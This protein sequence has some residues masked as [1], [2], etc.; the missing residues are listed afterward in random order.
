MTLLYDII[1]GRL[2][3]V[4]REIT[5][6]C[7]TLMNRA[8]PSLLRYM[9]Y[10]INSINPE[11]GPTY[12]LAKEYGQQLIENCR[13]A[14]TEDAVY[15][16]VHAPTAPHTEIDA[17]GNVAYSEVKRAG[18]RKLEAYVKE[19]AAG[20]RLLGAG[21]QV[22][23]DKAQENVAKLWTLIRNEPRLASSARPP[24]RACTAKSFDRWV[25]LAR[26]V[27]PLVRLL[28]TVA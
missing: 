19:M 26:L 11:K 10:H 12:A 21:S 24:S 6:R 2:T 14:Y 13:E 3:T 17:R 20:S 7:I 28:A 1:Y 18:V 8:D 25:L 5:A 22:N 15:K 9:Q 23:L 4:D 16:E 27:L